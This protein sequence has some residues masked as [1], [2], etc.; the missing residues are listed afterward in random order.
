MHLGEAEMHDSN[1]SSFFSGNEVLDE[2]IYN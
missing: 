2:L 1:G